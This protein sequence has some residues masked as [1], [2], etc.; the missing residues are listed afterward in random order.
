LHGAL[1]AIVLKAN[2]FAQKNGNNWTLIRLMAA[3]TVVYGH[4]FM[5]SPRKGHVDFTVKYLT[6]GFTYSGQMA[7]VV[8]FFLS[9]GLV[10]TSLIR[11]KNIWLWV[12]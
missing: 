2:I 4:S 10:T 1:S 3:C 9:G 5:I 12:L 8:F 11:T 7:V 6:N